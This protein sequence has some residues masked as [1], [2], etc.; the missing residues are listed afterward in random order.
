V[1]GNV[2]REDGTPLTGATVHAFSDAEEGCESLDIE[3][4]VAVTE[5]DGSFGLDLATGIV[6]E[7]VCVLVFA[8]P[9]AGVALGVSD[10]V[11]L[12]MDFRA[13]PAVDSAEVQLVLGAE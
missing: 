5:A 2:I 9:P 6:Q 1:I 7:R 12:V 11:L 8:R 3:F 13:E 4:G 10:T